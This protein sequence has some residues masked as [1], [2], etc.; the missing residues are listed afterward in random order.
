MTILTANCNSTAAPGP[1]WRLLS[2][3]GA[4]DA[5]NP[6]LKESHLLEGSREAGLGAERQ[7]TMK[8]GRNYIHERVVEWNEGRNYTIDIFAGTL[9]LR[10]IRTTMG[11]EPVGQGSQITMR[12]AYQ[13]KLGV[14]G[15]IIDPVVL[16][17][18]MRRMMHKVVR[19][20]ARKAEA[21]V[22]KSQPGS[23]A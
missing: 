17:P 16:R 11:V 5:F 23:A 12:M 7:C 18:M 22:P 9:P 1:I 4:I 2:D 20:L 13:P 14:F 15:R 3:F 10:D 21:G 8:D 19:G 6:L